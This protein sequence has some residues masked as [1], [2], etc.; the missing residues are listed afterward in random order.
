[1]NNKEREG[2][3]HNVGAES[4]PGG[5]EGTL[6]P[7]DERRLRKA[8][9]F[10]K[11]YGLG[12]ISIGELEKRNAP[13]PADAFLL[14]LTDSDFIRLEKQVIREYYYLGDVLPQVDRAHI[15]TVTVPLAGV[16]RVE[17]YAATVEPAAWVSGFH[18]L[19]KGSTSAYDVALL[20][21]ANPPEK[22]E[23]M[24]FDAVR[25]LAV[26][27]WRARLH[28]ACYAEIFHKNPKLY[29]RVMQAVYSYHKFSGQYPAMD[30]PEYYKLIHEG[31]LGNI[32]VEG[33][34]EDGYI[35]VPKEWL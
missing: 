12:P 21:S 8:A 4:R 25:V 6:T 11:A 5:M 9:N 28:A 29:D 34:I 3:E 33:L 32:Q 1:M 20:Y 14:T 15:V 35:T 27:A 19:T 17:V 7:E 23:Q 26:R 2:L 16:D 18:T 13:D 24:S 22:L 10:G 31:T 30:S